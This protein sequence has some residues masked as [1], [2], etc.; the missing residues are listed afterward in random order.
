[1]GTGIDIP[2][3]YWDIKNQRVKDSLPE[4]YG[5]PNHLNA[6]LKRMFRCVEDIIDFAVKRQMDAPLAFVK[7]TFTTDFNSVNLIEIGRS[8][9]AQNEKANMDVFFQIDVYT[10]SKMKKV[11]PKMEGIYRNMR[12][13]LAAFEIYRKRKI[14]FQ[15]MDYSFY[16]ELVEFLMYEYVQ[17]RY[18]CFP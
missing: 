3:S 6:E 8:M 11:T 7:N 13:R 16:E 4:D 2:P 14:T 17:K 1:L 5:N 15:E 9:D 18:K 12:A 10:K